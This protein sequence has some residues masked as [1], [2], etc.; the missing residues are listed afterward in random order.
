MA[1]GKKR[2]KSF[3][4]C[5][6]GVWYSSEYH[7]WCHQQPQPIAPPRTLRREAEAD[8]DD[9]LERKWGPKVAAA[10]VEILARGGTDSHRVR[11]SI[12]VRQVW[13][14]AS[15]NVWELSSE[16]APVT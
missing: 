2:E 11:A 3:Q 5:F 13:P 7:E 14:T 16:D 4:L 8:Y 15:K 6:Q 1:T 12:Q 9:R 10:N